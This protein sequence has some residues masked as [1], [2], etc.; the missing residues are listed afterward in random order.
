MIL[1]C[2]QHDITVKTYAQHA[3]ARL[4]TDPMS[5]LQLIL[6]MNEV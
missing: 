3:D 5:T 6:I 1:S 2:L 4:G